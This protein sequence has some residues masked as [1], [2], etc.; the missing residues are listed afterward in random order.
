MA[1]YSNVLK[2][3]TTA[4]PTKCILPLTWL[5]MHAFLHSK[6]TPN[7]QPETQQSCPKLVSFICL[8]CTWRSVSSVFLSHLR[9]YAKSS[10]L[11]EML[12][13]SLVPC[14]HIFTSPL[15]NSSCTFVIKEK[16]RTP[17]TIVF[18]N[19][20]CFSPVHVGAKLVT[21]CRSLLSGCIA[22]YFCWLYFGIIFFK[23]QSDTITKCPHMVQ[24][25]SPK[26]RL[27][28]RKQ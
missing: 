13:F 5:K 18:F 12:H 17:C 28:V 27:M 20:F 15:I 16:V 14:L 1:I 25:I 8:N 6:N 21:V 9:F 26:H 7:T 22:R 4:L 2:I 23:T 10:F 11:V 24:Y 3:K 19:H